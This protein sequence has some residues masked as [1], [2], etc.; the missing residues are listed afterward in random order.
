MKVALLLSG[1]FRNNNSKDYLYDKIISKYSTDVYCQCWYTSEES[2][3]QTEEKI[4]EAYAP[5]KLLM[6]KHIADYVE[7]IKLH[8]LN[9]NSSGGRKTNNQMHFSQLHGLKNVSNLFD[10]SQYDFIVRGRYDSC[11][12]LTFPDLTTLSKDNFYANCTY[13]MWIGAP[14]FF[15]DTSFILPN[16]FSNYF[17]L[18]DKLYDPEFIKN[19]YSWKENW[20]GTNFFPELFFS[21]YF[22]Y[23]NCWDKFVKL[24]QHQFLDITQ[25]YPASRQCEMFPF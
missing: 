22:E 25:N 5:K 9:L 18:F 16:T 13:N 17:N 7:L 24:E 21:Y 4:I 6:E 1:L 3:Q 10:W 15:M 19:M 20:N 2:K 14:K 12:I 23:Y 8:G 11:H